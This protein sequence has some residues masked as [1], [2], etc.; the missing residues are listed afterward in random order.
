MSYATQVAGEWLTRVSVLREAP[1]GD[2]G[3]PKAHKDYTGGRSS[4]HKVGNSLHNSV[5]FNFRN[6]LI[7]F[8]KHYKY[9]SG[10][11]AEMK[12]RYN[13]YKAL[14][15]LVGIFSSSFLPAGLTPL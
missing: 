15:L 5:F 9:T 10:S 12:G 11:R 13:D 3:P 7:N 6:S 2:T 1:Q 8:V 14:S 4:K